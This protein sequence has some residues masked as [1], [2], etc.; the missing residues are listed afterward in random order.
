M[1][2][3]LV[4]CANGT[5]TSLMMQEKAQISL[6]KLGVENLEIEHSDLNNNNLEK[7]D[8]IFCP[9]NFIDQFK[10]VEDKGIKLIGI[11]NILSEAEFKQ[12]LE[13]SGYLDEL[14]KK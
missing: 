13:E 11:K 8:L 5:G 9:I 10:H 6:I 7:Y 14:K 4:I 12:K 1:L 2:K 3:V